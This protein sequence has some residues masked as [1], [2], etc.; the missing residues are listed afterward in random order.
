MTEGLLLTGLVLTPPLLFHREIL[1]ACLMG[2]YLTL[3]AIATRDRG[4]LAIAGLAVMLDVLLENAVL[5]FFSYRY[6]CA[7]FGTLP[8]WGPLLWGCL[9]FSLTR[10]FLLADRR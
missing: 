10:L 3:R 1:L 4:E 7:S 6:A 8:L 9:T 2:A 5:Q